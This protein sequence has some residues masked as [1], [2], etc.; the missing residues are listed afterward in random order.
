MSYAD[1]VA[2]DQSDLGTS[3]ALI[4]QRDFILEFRSDCADI[5]AGIYLHGP[6]M[7]YGDVW[8]GKG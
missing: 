3:V 6:Y 2:P 4:S 5:Q 1:N 8:R 7:A